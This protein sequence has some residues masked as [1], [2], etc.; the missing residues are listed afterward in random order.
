[1]NKRTL[2]SVLTALVLSSCTTDNKNSAL[3]V[4]GTVLATVGVV[5]L[6]DGTTTSSCTFSSAS[7]ESEFPVFTPNGINDLGAT[8]FLV[9]NQLIPPTN[10]NTVFNTD[11]TTFSPHQAVVNYEIVGGGPT[12]AEQII[13]TSGGAVASNTTQAVIVPL[14]LPSAALAVL[15]GLPA[16]GGVV[17]ATVRIEGKLDDGSTVSTSEHEYVVVVNTNPPVPPATVATGTNS[18]CF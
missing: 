13:P 1:M 15:K 3:V 12:I 17:R 9:S 8:G 14:F 18:P 7:S 6:P 4:T 11:S 2:G 16:P 5:T 10:I